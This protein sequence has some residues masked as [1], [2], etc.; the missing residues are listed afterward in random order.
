MNLESAKEWLLKD[1][2]N[3]LKVNGWC[4][5]SIAQLESDQ[6]NLHMETLS[7]EEWKTRCNSFKGEIENFPENCS[8]INLDGK[9]DVNNTDE[10]KCPYCGH[11]QSDSWEYSGDSGTAECDFCEKGFE[12]TR[13]IFVDYSTEKTT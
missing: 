2:N 5:K 6:D 4:V 11:E 9:H 8:L 1:P 13:N 7:V 12:Y 10:I 3:A